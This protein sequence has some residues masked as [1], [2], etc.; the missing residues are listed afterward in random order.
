MG[1]A[2]CL[3]LLHL[4][5]VRPVKS[6]KAPF[7]RVVC[8]PAAF[9]RVPAAGQGWGWQGACGHCPVPPRCPCG[10]VELPVIFHYADFN[11]RE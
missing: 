9:V 11:W 10:A 2:N 7:L 3:K 8:S 1:F 5:I 6:G 4:I